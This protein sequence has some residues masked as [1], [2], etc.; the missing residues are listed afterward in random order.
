MLHDPIVNFTA[1]RGVKSFFEKSEWFRELKSG[2]APNQVFL[3]DQALVVFQKFFAAPVA[4]PEKFVVAVAARIGPMF[5]T[6]TP[7]PRVL[8][9]FNF[10]TNRH[11]ILIQQLA[12]ALP[13]LGALHTNGADYVMGGLY[14]GTRT[15]NAP[16]TELM[17]QLERPNL[18][19]YDWEITA[20]SAKHWRAIRQLDDI[21]FMRPVIPSAAAGQKWFLAAIPKMG[22]T[23]TEVTRVSPTEWN[24]LRSSPAGLTG[25][26][27]AQL[28]WWIDADT[29]GTSQRTWRPG[30]RLVPASPS[31]PVKPKP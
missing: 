1:A 4:N 25:F 15:T 9:D 2:D 17:R 28:I 23:V 20:E 18:V 27:L 30:T 21:A 14:M 3:W 19:A 12:G 10:S 26:E 16:P 24:V 13:L 22:N 11:S 31:R 29:R 7:G 6:N 5:D 8:G